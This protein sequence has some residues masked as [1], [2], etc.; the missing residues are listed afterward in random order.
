[1]RSSG[2]AS[3]KGAGRSEPADR[4][5]RDIRDQVVVAV[6]V[7]QWN[8]RGLCRCCDEQILRRHAAMLPPR[9][10]EG[11]NGPSPTPLFDADWTRCQE[12]EQAA[13]RAEGGRI[14]GA[15]QEFER[16]RLAYEDSALMNLCVE[17]VC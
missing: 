4:L 13:L 6:V 7:K 11:L 15:T 14:L 2:R 5:P 10:E 9:G 16:H 1:M 3:G 8:G 12:V 17:P